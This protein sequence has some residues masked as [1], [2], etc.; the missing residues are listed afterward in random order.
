MHRI[1]QILCTLAAENNQII[2]AGK[3]DQQAGLS[4]KR[5]AARQNSMTVPDFQ[6]ALRQTAQALA[7]LDQ[8]GM[9]RYVNPAFSAMF[10]YAEADILGRH[11]SV[12]AP[13]GMDDIASHQAVIA[14]A[15]PTRP[16]QGEVKRI[17]QGGQTL[18]VALSCSVMTDDDGDIGGYVLTYTDMA[19]RQA[20]E[21]A[22]QQAN[23][24]LSLALD[25]SQLSLWDVDIPRDVV[26]LDARWLRMLGHP[27]RE[28][29]LNSQ[30][31]L[32]GVHPDDF[33]AVSRAT[34]AML[35]GESPRFREEFRYRNAEGGWNWIRSTG[36]VV[37]RDHNGRALRAIGTNQDVTE[38]K[39]QEEQIIS[40]AHYDWLTGLPN[41][42]SL[43]RHLDGALAR[44]QRHQ[45]MVAVCMID[46][47]D[48]K[49][50]NDT[51]GHET[52][53]ILLQLFARRLQDLLRRSDFVARLGGD[54]F[55]VVIEDLEETGLLN[56]LSATLNKL[57]QAVES[58]FAL[59]A[60]NEAEVGMTVGV[61]LFPHDGADA[62]A[63]MR[64][65]DVAMYQAKQHKSSRRVW[66]RMAADETEYH[67]E[68]AGSFEVYGEE[69]A[70]LLQ[71]ASKVVNAAIE[72]Y[73]AHFYDLDGAPED[74]LRI[75]RNLSPAN[76]EGLKP[77][78]RN[79]IQ[80]LLTTDADAATIHA[81][82]L[83]LGKV[84]GLVGVTPAMLVQSVELFRHQF[85][86]QL[87]QTLLPASQRYR[88]LE[89]V[90]SRLQNQLHGQLKAAAQV[91]SDYL[92]VISHPMPHQGTLWAD[93]VNSELD[94]LGKLPGVQAVLL[95]RLMSNGVFV[96]ENSRG[97]KGEIVANILQTPGKESVVDPTSP[98]GQGLSAVAWRTGNICS[99][100][101][102]GHD[103]RYASWYSQAE[104]YRIRSTMSV[105][106]RNPEGLTVA[107]ISFFG[108]YPNQFESNAMRQFA[109]GLQHRWELI[110]TACT[111]PA[112]AIQQNLA[113]AL[114]ERLFAGGL[115]M[116]LQPVVDLR[117]GKTVKVEAL[118][119]LRQDNGDIVGPGVFLP[120]LGDADMDHLFRLGLD[121]ALGQLQAFER[122]GLAIDVS[123]NIAPA[124]LLDDNCASWVDDA[125]RQHGVDPRRLSLELLETEDIPPQAQDRAIER[126]RRTGIKLAMDDLGSGYSSLQRLSS[127]PFDCIKVDQGL[128]LNLR[129]NPLPSLALIRAILQLGR[130]LER[131]VV[132]EGLEDAG[133]L[134][135]AMILGADLGQ[136]Y[137]LAKPMEASRFVAWQA[138]FQPPAHRDRITT[139]LGALAQHWLY[140]QP[141]HTEARPEPQHCP[142]QAFLAKRPPPAWQDPGPDAAPADQAS[143]RLTA[144]L[145]EQACAERL[146]S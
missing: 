43:T 28:A 108:A 134:E 142:L 88:L 37:A 121:K 15:S 82:S 99:V 138:G 106:V 103:P 5:A 107:V 96:P 61:A 111:K 72:H 48:F 104:D 110:L 41:R 105:P 2:P 42:F 114:R 125:L 90:D 64:Q 19:D 124:T 89:I 80:R 29:E 119:R 35:R 18:G 77:L 4:A 131:Q 145:A 6:L 76:V 36:K 50:V 67:A 136:G 60:G 1:P 12:I 78:H 69:A 11:I 59:G 25:A 54:E 141:S 70:R 56:K 139:Y 140:T 143:Q 58:P 123:L 74:Y 68:E 86:Q 116:F 34:I 83:R 63:L 9:V 115:E 109:Q 100:A 62:D 47:D 49:P 65:A 7:I 95:M 26:R 10:G 23:E 130:D 45:S 52:G 44:A 31:L 144:W 21:E 22:L 128:T 32:S 127:Q 146:S 46:L 98:R 126:L 132:V 14:A 53:D 117:S 101:A 93:A 51:W 71:K 133:M 81:E 3:H 30:T 118:A 102:Y 27:P 97:P 92:E 66:W 39:R 17:T 20:I 112:A 122:Q 13:S 33:A 120:L 55:L 57:H 135:A 73:I 87:N 113:I 91:Q 24:R 79:F 40:A 137:C 16:F 8:H 85:S 38:H 75:L 129:K 94:L 84:H